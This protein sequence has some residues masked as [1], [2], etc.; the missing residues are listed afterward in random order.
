M[1]GIENEVKTLAIP[2]KFHTKK[3]GYITAYEE[4]KTFVVY[5]NDVNL[6]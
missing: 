1:F 4:K 2:L 6:F 5:F 3:I